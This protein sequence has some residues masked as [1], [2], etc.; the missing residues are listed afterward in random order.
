MRVIV[1]QLWVLSEI[2]LGDICADVVFLSNTCFSESGNDSTDEAF[3]NFFEQLLRRVFH[4][5]GT[6]RLSSPYVILNAVWY[7]VL[8]FHVLTLY[9]TH[10]YHWTASFIHC[11]PTKTQ[12]ILVTKYC[13]NIGMKQMNLSF[14]EIVDN[15]QLSSLECIKEC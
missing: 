4:T 15:S 10:L 3:Q 7:L 11:N 13:G 8:V 2:L 5:S 12:W 1:Q 9:D 14:E 6:E